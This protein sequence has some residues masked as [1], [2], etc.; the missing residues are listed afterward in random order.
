MVQSCVTTNSLRNG[1]V[2]WEMQEQKCQQRVCQQTDVAQPGQAGW[3]VLILQWKMVK[4]EGR[5]ALVIA[6]PI[7]DSLQRFLWKTVDPTSSTNFKSHPRVP[8]ATV[9]KTEYEANV[10]G[11]VRGLINRSVVTCTRF[12]HA[13]YSTFLLYRQYYQ[14]FLTLVANK[15][16]FH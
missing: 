5:S 10:L 12:W 2:L 15:Y 8:R 6:L 1:I 7:A 4:F 3:M 11:V 14:Q 16:L 13:T 9:V